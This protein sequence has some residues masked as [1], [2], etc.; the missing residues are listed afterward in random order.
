VGC[1]ERS[2]DGAGAGAAGG[3]LVRVGPGALPAGSVGT[4]GR[5]RRAVQKRK[6]PRTFLA[7]EA[8]FSSAGSG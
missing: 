2:R 7:S 6:G 1:A 3:V 5:Y 4:V 8:Q